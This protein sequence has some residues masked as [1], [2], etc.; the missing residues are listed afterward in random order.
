MWF[1][2]SINKI[3]NR[4][5][6]LEYKSELRITEGVRMNNYKQSQGVEIPLSICYKISQGKAKSVYVVINNEDK[7]NFNKLK[8]EN[9]SVDFTYKIESNIHE[10]TKKIIDM[11]MVYIDYQ[12]NLYYEYIV[13]YPRYIEAGKLR[14]DYGNEGSEEGSQYMLADTEIQTFNKYELLSESLYTNSVKKDEFDVLEYSKL[15]REIDELKTC[16]SKII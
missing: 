3:D 8:E 12:D 14:A 5:R 7:M 10:I 9:G 1:T 13:M 2:W 6:S 16:V 4:N 15:I 11:Y